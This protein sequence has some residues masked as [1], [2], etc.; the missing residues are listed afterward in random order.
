MCDICQF[1]VR[2][3]SDELTEH[4][5][6]CPCVSPPAT[7]YRNINWSEFKTALSRRGCWVFD[8]PKADAPT[9]VEK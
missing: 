9:I 7:G 6:A 2:E 4:H 3:A 8:E 1:W 5:P